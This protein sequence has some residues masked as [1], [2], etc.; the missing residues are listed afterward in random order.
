MSSW[1]W[2]AA[3]RRAGV[4]RDGSFNAGAIEIGHRRALVWKRAGGAV[5][6]FSGTELQALSGRIASALERFGV[7][8]GDRVAGLLGRRPESFAL[9]LAVWRIGAI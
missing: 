4:G 6:P 1:D 8:R 9:P 5:V 7:R 2:Q 3:A